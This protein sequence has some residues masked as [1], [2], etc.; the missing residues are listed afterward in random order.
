MLA[1]FE[2]A[3]RN[4]VTFDNDCAFVQH[5]LL[6]TIRAMTTWFCDAY[7]SWQKG[8]GE[9]ANGRLRCWLPRRIDRVR[10]NP[11]HRH[12]ISTPLI[13]FE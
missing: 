1:V 5:A 12:P 4:S 13:R 7:A 9:N 11:G 2:S 6:R 8:G 3:L 10:R